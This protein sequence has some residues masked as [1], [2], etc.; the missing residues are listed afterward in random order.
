MKKEVRTFFLKKR[1][2]LTK[3]EILKRSD[4]IEKNI[5]SFPRFQ[6]ALNAM[7]F[8]SFGKEPYTHKIIEH[9]LKQKIVLAPKIFGEALI[10]CELNSATAFV[11][12]QYNVLEPAEEKF[13]PTSKIEIIFVPG[14]AFTEKGDRIGY[15]KGYFD[16]FLAKTSAY[17]IGLCFDEFITDKLPM[18][19]YDVKMDAIITDKRVIVVNK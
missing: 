17:K 12:G 19:S 10:P 15:G 11:K 4:A 1:K 18:H 6:K 9:A 16:R 7:F 2:E 13:F 5:F 8:I 3:E 14:L